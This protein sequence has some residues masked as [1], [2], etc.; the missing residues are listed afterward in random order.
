MEF[1][2]F[3]KVSRH[4]HSH[5][6]RDGSRKSYGVLHIENMDLIP[7]IGHRVKVKVSLQVPVSLKE[8]KVK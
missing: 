6:R 8:K 7:F 2:S 3:L 5:I 4:R 1:T